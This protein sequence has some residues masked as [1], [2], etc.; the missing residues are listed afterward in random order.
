[1]RD[2]IAAHVDDL[3]DDPGDTSLVARTVRR[4]NK[5]AEPDL[6][7]ILGKAAAA[8]KATLELLFP[9]FSKL[10]GAGNGDRLSRRR[11]LVRLLYFGNPPGA[12]PRSILDQL[13]SNTDTTDLEAELPRADG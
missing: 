9:R 2:Q 11:N 13:W 10:S 4:M 3:V 5:D 12:V 6:V 7:G 8:Q 1:M